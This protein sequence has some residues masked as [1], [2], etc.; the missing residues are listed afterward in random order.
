MKPFTREEAEKYLPDVPD[1]TLSA[2]NLKISKEYK[3]KDF[4][5]AIN[6]VNKVSEIA[7]SEGHHPDIEVHYN[8]VRLTNWTHAIGGLSENDFILAAKIDASVGK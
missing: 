4:I 5:G 8:K 1:W 3:F 6:F 7:E 2:D